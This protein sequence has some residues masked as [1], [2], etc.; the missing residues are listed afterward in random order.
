MKDRTNDQQPSRVREL[1]QDGE[2]RGRWGWVE[3]AVW[4]E[5]MLEA[6]ETGVRGGKWHSLYDKVYGLSNL[7]AAWEQVKANRGGGRRGQRCRSPISTR[8]PITGWRSCPK[9]LRTRDVQASSRYGESASRKRGSS[10]KRPLG[11]PTIIDRIVQTACG[12]SSNR[13]SSRSS[14]QCS[15]GFRPNRGARTRWEKSNDCSQPG[16]T[17]VVDVDIEQV[18]RHDPAS[19]A[20]DER[21]REARSPMAECS[22]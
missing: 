13:S 14:T 10:E 8:T 22:I 7:K 11:I 18:L 4:T 2:I 17:W 9:Q 20:S 19:R 12:T 6:L 16:Q 1:E 21:S 5:R 15:Y 3:P